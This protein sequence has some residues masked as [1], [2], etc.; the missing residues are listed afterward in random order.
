MRCFRGS[1]LPL[2]SLTLLSAIAA[3][4]IALGTAEA[5]PKR[6]AALKDCKNVF[7]DQQRTCPGSSNPAACM[8]M[9]TDKYESCKA[10]ANT[11]AEMSDGNPPKPPKPAIPKIKP[12]PSAAY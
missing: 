1:K 4:C 11:I 3:A 2:A 5:G 8:T 7:D 9:I 6:D 12:A 10:D